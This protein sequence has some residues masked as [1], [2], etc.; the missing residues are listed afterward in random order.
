[1]GKSNITQKGLKRVIK[2]DPST[3]VFNWIVSRGF[4]I[5]G[6]V[7]K[8]KHKITYNGKLYAKT[9]LAWLYMTGVNPD[10]PIVRVDGN[11][12]NYK[13]KNLEL[14]SSVTVNIDHNDII[15][16]VDDKSYHMV[17]I[18]DGATVDLGIHGEYSL[19]IDVLS[20]Y[21]CSV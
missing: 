16:M 10:E 12:L 11:E 19:T 6:T 13:F 21:L 20:K 3:G 1:M 14:K 5:R 17:V 4:I 8:G 7:C 9:R 2:Y 15:C 18:K